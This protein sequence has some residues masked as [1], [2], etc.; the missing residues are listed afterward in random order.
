VLRTAIRNYAMRSSISLPVLVGPARGNR[1][2]LADIG[3]RRFVPF[4]FGRH[5]R[6]VVGFLNEKLRTARVFADLGAGDGY[7]TRVALS[8]LPPGGIVIA[9]E[10]RKREDLLA[11]AEDVGPDRLVVRREALGKADREEAFAFGADFGYATARE[12][13]PV[14]GDSD[15]RMIQFRT[16]DSLIAEGSVPAPDVVKVDVEGFEADALIG[17]NELLTSSHPVLAVECHSIRLLRDVLGMLDVTGY[18]NVIVARNR[19]AGGPWHVLTQPAWASSTVG[20]V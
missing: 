13:L 7:Y 5:E 8:A 17:M 3:P 10:P 20:S 6:A 19:P 12:G 14:H 15:V 2:R 4:L 9:F 11:L 1:I 16:L 18:H